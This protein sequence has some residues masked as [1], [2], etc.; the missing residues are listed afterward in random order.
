LTFLGVTEKGEE[1]RNQK[2]GRVA[3]QE[4]NEIVIKGDP[5]GGVASGRIVHDQRG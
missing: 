3:G 1:C 4:N 2:N 5:L